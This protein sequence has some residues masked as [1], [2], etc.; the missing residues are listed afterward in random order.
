M[1]L[2]VEHFELFLLKQCNLGAFGNV[3][4]HPI[5]ALGFADQLE[6]LLVKVDVQLVVVGLASD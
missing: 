6:D 1:Q 5:E 2:P 4:S 3:Q